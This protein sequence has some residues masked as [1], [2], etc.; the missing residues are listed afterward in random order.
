MEFQKQKYNE[1]LAM[2]KGAFGESGNGGI[3]VPS[4][5]NEAVNLYQPGGQ[6]GAGG[7]AEVAEAGQKALAAGQIG[8]AS[9]GMSS[10]TNVAGLGARIY[11]DTGIANKKIEDERVALLGG[12][13]GQAGNAELE[14]ER[15]R[16]SREATLMNTLSS[17]SRV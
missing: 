12:A 13:L 14:A 10:G 17:F 5:F 1:I 9:T 2:Y 7:K 4:Q 16:A 8:L 3:N 11:A 6:F 15:L